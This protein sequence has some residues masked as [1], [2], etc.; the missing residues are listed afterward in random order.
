[1]PLIAFDS[2]QEFLI[3]DRV[4]DAPNCDERKLDEA[5]VLAED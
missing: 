1:M 5:V 3:V 2:G 4:G